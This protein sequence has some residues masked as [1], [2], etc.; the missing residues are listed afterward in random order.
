MTRNEEA[1]ALL[2]QLERVLSDD[3]TLKTKL[4]AN[5]I[6]FLY[7]CKISTFTTV[8]PSGKKTPQGLLSCII[9]NLLETTKEQKEIQQ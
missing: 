2:I 3:P 6:N 4:S 8:T 1:H 9:D 5:L 7:K